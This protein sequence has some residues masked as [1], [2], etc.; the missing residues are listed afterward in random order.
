MP[1]H[2]RDVLAVDIIQL[3]EQTLVGPVLVEFQLVQAANFGHVR[4]QAEVED[5]GRVVRHRGVV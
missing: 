5:G 2:G 4:R 1:F 3:N